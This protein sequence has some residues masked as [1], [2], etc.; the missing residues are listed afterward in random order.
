[1]ARNIL[2]SDIMRKDVIALEPR[3]RVG[4]LMDIIKSTKHHAFPVVDR[5]EPGLTESQL[6]NYGR[7]KG[8]ILR[9]QIFTILKKKHFAKDF[10]DPFIE[11]IGD[12]TMSDF[13]ESYPG[14]DSNT[15][16]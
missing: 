9:S 5:I 13:T 4:R 15:L 10:D 1:M 11:G 12:L 2:A 16:N 3:E 14:L 7:L 8:L 6:P